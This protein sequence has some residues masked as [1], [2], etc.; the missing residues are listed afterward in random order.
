MYSK[1]R[2][3]TAIVLSFVLIFL[4][5]AIEFTHHHNQNFPPYKDLSIFEGKINNLNP[6]NS[7]TFVCLA[8]VYGLSHIAPLLTFE[9][10]NIDQ[11]SWFTNFK[12]STFFHVFFP[13]PFHL[14]APPFVA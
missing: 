3:I 6:L 2:K 4:T 14:R 7:H 10:L 1:W 11:K 9:I 12:E 13:T 8:C 5:V